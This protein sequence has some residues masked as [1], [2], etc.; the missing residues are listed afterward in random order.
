MWLKG[1][2]IANNAISLSANNQLAIPTSEL[3]YIT[4]LDTKSV[5]IIRLEL[6]PRLPKDDVLSL[7]N[8]TFERI[9]KTAY[10]DLY[11]L[12][13]T[14]YGRL[15]LYDTVLEREVCTV[16]DLLEDIG[17]IKEIKVLECVGVNYIFVGNDTG[18]AAIL[19]FDRNSQNLVSRCIFDAH[20]NWI[21]MISTS[22]R[23]GD[24]L[25]IGTGSCEG[26]VSLW[27]YNTKLNQ[28]ELVEIVSEKDY[29]ICT[30]FEFK[31]FGENVFVSLAKCNVVIVSQIGLPNRTTKVFPVCSIVGLVWGEKSADYHTLRVY[32][33][34]AELYNLEIDLHHSAIIN[35][36]EETNS[37]RS[38]LSSSVDTGADD[39]SD[40]GSEGGYEEFCIDGIVSSQHNLL[41]FIV[42][43]Q[44]EP[45]SNANRTESK[46]VVHRSE[47]TF[48][49]IYPMIDLLRNDIQHGNLKKQSLI[50][51]KLLYDLFFCPEKRENLD[52][53]I[54][55]S[56]VT[57]L[58]SWYF[59]IKQSESKDEPQILNLTYYFLNAS[60]K[61]WEN[62]LM[63]EQYRAL[64]SNIEVKASKVAASSILEKLLQK[65]KIEAI[66]LQD[67]DYKILENMVAQ[68]E[69]K[70]M[71]KK[72]QKHVPNI[73]INS[74][75]TDDKCAI[76]GGS[77]P[78]S[79]YNDAQCISQ[80]TLPAALALPN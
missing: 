38:H 78:F 24:I 26:A 68:C 72:L 12:I 22:T 37:L 14:T 20:E 46:I 1:K 42:F 9:R 54:I 15:V 74:R 21:A 51:A 7:Q 59:H 25:Y 16:N 13:L 50:P 29:R 67:F 39:T 65:F 73:T 34:D 66:D 8:W 53:N 79:V 62:T 19:E 75:P 44:F 35:V 40:A 36:M 61:V 43:E 52:I 23:I 30:A 58:S 32:T 56:V 33:A 2:P 3:I 28:V 71:I 31:N 70:T 48:P 47:Y 76:C 64:L 6:R 5:N 49:S 57:L 18:K 60:E 10:C 41:D 80:I 55:D 27:K 69:D 17:V 63:S 4:S 11:L 45:F 77:I